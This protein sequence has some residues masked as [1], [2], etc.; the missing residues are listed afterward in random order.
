MAGRAVTTIIGIW[1]SMANA[2]T[3][4][5]ESLTFVKF[6]HMYYRLRYYITKPYSPGE[7]AMKFQAFGHWSLSSLDDY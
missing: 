5:A 4:A 7:I 3:F 2:F 6:S 1:S